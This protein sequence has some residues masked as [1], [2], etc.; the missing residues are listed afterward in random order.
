MTTRTQVTFELPP[1]IFG[2]QEYLCHV[3]DYYDDEDSIGGPGDTVTLKT[4]DVIRVYHRNITVMHS[5][6]YIVREDGPELLGEYRTV[7]GRE[8]HDWRDHF[9][10]QIDELC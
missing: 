6:L 4:E 3:V 1:E 7:I 9:S 10:E 2:K 8:G 5:D